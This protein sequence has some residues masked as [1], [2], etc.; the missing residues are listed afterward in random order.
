MED[1]RK[2]IVW[3]DKDTGKTKIANKVFHDDE[4]INRYYK[5]NRDKIES[6]MIVL[7][8]NHLARIKKIQKKENEQGCKNAEK[9]ESSGAMETKEILRR[10]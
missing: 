4:S 8:F 3:S 10:T 1:E 6:L 7:P 9:N 5:Y 2:I